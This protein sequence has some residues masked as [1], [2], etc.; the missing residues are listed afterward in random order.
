MNKSASFGKSFG[1]T[2]RPLKGMTEKC[3]QAIVTWLGK[4]DGAHAVTEMEGE[5]RHIHAQIWIKEGR[6]KG[7][8]CTAMQR[9]GERT[10]VDWNQQQTTVLR[11]GI[12]LC[13]SDWYLD[14]CVTNDNKIEEANILIDNVPELT[15]GFY[16]SEEEQ[17]ALKNKVHAVDKKYHNL[18][19]KWNVYAAENKIE[20]ISIRHTQTALAYWMYVEK[21]LHVI[22][23]PRRKAWTVRELFNYVKGTGGWQTCA[24]VSEITEEREFQK[25]KE[26]FQE[27]CDKIPEE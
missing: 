10:I 6:E 26:S 7:Q 25:L 17:E 21:S 23:D 2:F 22:E 5:C 4:Q 14:Y 18:L 12:K 8:I 15:M 11:K 20:E 9:I 1:I 3:E 27:S 24:T 16:P 13:Y 19:E